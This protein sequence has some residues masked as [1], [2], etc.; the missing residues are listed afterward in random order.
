MPKDRPFK[1]MIGDTVNVERNDFNGMIFYKVKVSKNNNGTKLYGY[2]PVRFKK[3][4]SLENG[5]RIIIKD[6]FEDF[7]NKDRFNTVFS[8]FITDFEIAQPDVQGALE[9]YEKEKLGV[10]DEDVPW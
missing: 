3:D 4:V 7:Y 9:E 1:I 5:T 10:E 8:L 2:K 6:M